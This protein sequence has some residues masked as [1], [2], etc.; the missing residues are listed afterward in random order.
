[1]NTEILI[2]IVGVLLV[3]GII[4]KIAKFLLFLLVVSILV[5]FY[6]YAVENGMIENVLALIR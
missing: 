6:F 2:L 4:K 5:L 3:F 1:M